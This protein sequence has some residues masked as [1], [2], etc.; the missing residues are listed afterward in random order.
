M[1]TDGCG[2]P[3][4][5]AQPADETRFDWSPVRTKQAGGPQEFT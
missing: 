3:E 4:P 5:D 1:N 2:Q